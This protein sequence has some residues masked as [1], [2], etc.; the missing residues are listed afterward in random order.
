MSRGQA[1]QTTLPKSDRQLIREYVDTNSPDAFAELANRHANWV[2]SSALRRVRDSH[3]AEDVAQAV[4][5]I[6]SEKASKILSNVPLNAWLFQ[7]TR[8]A[9][10]HA[11]RAKARRARHERIAATMTSEISGSNEETVWQRVQP[12]LDDLVGLLRDDDRQAIL[13]RFFEQRSMAEV[14]SALNVSEEAAKKRVARALEQLRKLLGRKGVVMP[15][16]GLGIAMAVGMA[17]SAPASV[18]ATCASGTAPPASLAARLIASQTIGVM[19]GA[20]IKLAVAVVLVVFLVSAAGVGTYFVCA[21]PGLQPTPSDAVTAAVAPP[22]NVQPDPDLAALQ[23]TWIPTSLRINGVV[24]GERFQGGQL[25]IAGSSFVYSN[26]YW[27]DVAT[28]T[29]NNATTPPHFN[30]QEKGRVSHG[31]FVVEGN[32]LK[33]CWGPFGG[34]RPEGFVTEVG[35]DR[36]VVEFE[37]VGVC[38]RG[39]A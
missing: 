6:L 34:E 27:K 3:L 26:S 15:A 10:A 38:S 23:G 19:V 35:D 28:I 11:L 39:G 8:Y 31:L 33:M 12:W 14:G 2:Y 9:S 36:R 21:R 22:L 17:Q 13:L 25:V 1:V 32:H 30:I 18:L 7:V 4:F 24:P 37:R 16:A 20:K 5:I 29:V